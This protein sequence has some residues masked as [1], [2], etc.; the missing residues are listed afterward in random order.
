MSSIN[1]E[2]PSW[3]DIVDDD[4]LYQQIVIWIFCVLFIL[5]LPLIIIYYFYGLN[6]L[7]FLM[8]LRKRHFKLLRF[9]FI[10]ILMDLII[11]E[12]I[13]LLFGTYLSNPSD[14]IYWIYFILSTCSSQI[15]IYTLLL[16]I[17][18]LFFDIKWIKI[19]C[20]DDN[21]WRYHI[22]NP[23][24]LISSSSSSQQQQS[25]GVHS[26]IIPQT[27]P[28]TLNN[29]SMSN[30]SRKNG[31]I[32]RD[33]DRT[34]LKDIDERKNIDNEYEDHEQHP[35]ILKANSN[36]NVNKQPV[37]SWFVKYRQSAGNIQYIYKYFIIITII[38][39]ILSM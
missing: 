16:K 9:M 5:V 39:I 11:I 12:P 35:N 14:I 3:P 24:K 26:N 7:R 28:S 10:V 21:Q 6:K 37:M 17:W 30:N 19:C 27:P 15:F 23:S 25:N 34:N 22:Y 38:S 8:G 20:I 32:N 36:L 2:L 33:R 29:N 4:E 1:F 13:R 18:L 31:K